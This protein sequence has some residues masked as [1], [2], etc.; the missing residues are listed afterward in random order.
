VSDKEFIEKY[1]E[2]LNCGYC[3][4][5]ELNCLDNNP[6]RRI[7]NIMKEQQNIN[8]KLSLALESA[9]N[10]IDKA[11]NIIS[12]IRMDRDTSIET[13][14]ALDEILNILKGSEP[15]E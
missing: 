2:L 12:L 9:E 13:H 1:E 11:I 6:P 5:N 3:E 4:C 7:L 15:N 8:E 10:R 14:K